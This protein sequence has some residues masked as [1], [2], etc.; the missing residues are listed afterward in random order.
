[1][2]VAIG[3][4]SGGLEAMITMLQHLPAAYT[5]PTVL[6]LHQRANRESG[7]PEMLSR[8][9]HL[10]VV[11]P[12]DKQRIDPGYLYVAPPNYHLLVER[13]KT[14]SLSLDAPV[15]Y[16]RPSIDMLLESAAI[17]YGA[18]LIACVLSGANAD[19]TAGAQIVKQRGGRVYVQTPESSTMPIMPLS[20]AKHVSIDGAFPPVVLAQQLMTLMAARRMA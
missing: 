9:T 19:G 13:E 7:V 8:Y 11:E 20:V 6:V 10:A 18:N 16:S 1:M 17:A 5:T 15:N 3:A 2:L 12:E 4:S 14:F